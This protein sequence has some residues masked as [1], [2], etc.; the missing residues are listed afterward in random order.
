MIPRGLYDF[1]NGNRSLTQPELV[2]MMH[3]IKSTARLGPYV[4]HIVQMN[5]VTEWDFI[6]FNFMLGA[7]KSSVKKSQE[8]VM[9]VSSKLLLISGYIS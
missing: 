4:E 7:F 2:T 3:E 8:S 9:L 1:I 6:I 5:P